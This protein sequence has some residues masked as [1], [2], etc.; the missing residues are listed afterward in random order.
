MASKDAKA[1]QKAFIIRG[2][3]LMGMTAL[4]Y[5]ATSDDDEYIKTRARSSG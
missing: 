1:I 3:F 2:L 4:Y 5:A